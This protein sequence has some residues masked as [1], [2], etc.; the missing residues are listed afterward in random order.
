[1]L[2]IVECCTVFLPLQSFLELKINFVVGLHHVN[3]LKKTDGDVDWDM[4][5]D[6]V[7]RAHRGDGRN[8]LVVAFLQHQELA[9]YFV[10]L[11]SAVS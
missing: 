9:A 3:Y 5:Y 6:T 11:V 8:L 4:A 10:R 7:K 1:M 2:Q